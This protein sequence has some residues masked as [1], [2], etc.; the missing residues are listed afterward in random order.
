MTSILENLAAKRSRAVVAG[1]N[2][3]ADNLDRL[4][5]SQ[6]RVEIERKERQQARRLTDD[7]K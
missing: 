5:E 3:K 6:N 7:N 4:I 2:E 1:N